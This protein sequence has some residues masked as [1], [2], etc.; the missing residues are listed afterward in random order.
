MNALDLILQRIE[1]AFSS[2]LAALIDRSPTLLLAGV[3]VL[4]GWLVARALRW[5]VTR[6]SAVGR[7]EALAERTGVLKVLKRAGMSSLGALLGAVT[8][9]AVILGTVMLAAE[10]LGMTPVIEGIERVF[11]YM[12][13]LLA[14]LGVF[15]FGYWLADKARFVMGT[16]GEA[17]G[18]GGGKVIGRVLFVI[19]LLFLTITALNVAGVDTTLITSNILIVVGSLFLAFSIAYGFA[20]KDILTNILSSYYG[21]DRFKPGMRVRIGA[22]EGVS[23]RIDGISITLRADGKQ[24]IIPTAALIKDRIEVKMDDHQ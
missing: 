11:A 18:V 12:P 9:W 14:A 7:L 10:V 20:A 15:L 3:V 13:S 2:T 1:Q 16:M 6:L 19:I 21:K 5:L 22:D 17:M 8:Y 4:L 24:I 23:E